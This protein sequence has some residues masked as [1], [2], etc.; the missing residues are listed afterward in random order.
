MSSEYKVDYAYK[1][2]STSSW[3][4]SSYR[5]KAESEAMAVR[6]VEDRHPG[7]DIQIRSVTKTK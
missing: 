2:P 4:S 1:K 5:A 7:H 6:I 3:T